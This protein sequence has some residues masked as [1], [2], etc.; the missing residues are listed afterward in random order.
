MAFSDAY[1]REFEHEA[2]STRKALERIP[3]DKFDWAPHEKSMKLG[4]L[5]AHIA[6]LPH[7]SKIVLGG[8]E[9][10]AKSP[11]ASAA[12]PPALTTTKELL[13]R[14]DKSMEQMRAAVGATTEEKLVEVFTLRAGPDII[15]TLP[16]RVALRS[17]ILNHMI[18]HRGQL[19][20]YLRLL[21]IPVPSIYGPSADE[22]S[23]A[24]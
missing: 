18:H 1:V 4:S 10:D 21:G 19:S 16:R 2:I 13:D 12:R 20:V 9:F 23:A 14:W 8:N 7:R 6:G 3:A 24:V 5:A 15:F 17:F 22:K 11:E